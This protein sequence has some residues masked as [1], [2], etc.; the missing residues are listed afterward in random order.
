MNFRKILPRSEIDIPKS[1]EE[2]TELI[3]KI[4]H[5]EIKRKFASVDSTPPAASKKKSLVIPKSQKLFLPLASRNTGQN[6]LGVLNLTAYPSS[7]AT[8]SP[9]KSPRSIL[10]EPNSPR[11]KA[12]PSPKLSVLK[13]RRNFQESLSK[14]EGK[15]EEPKKE[16]TR[17]K[18]AKEEAESKKQ[19]HREMVRGLFGK[20]DFLVCGGL[21]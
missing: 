12:S 6:D 19:E 5:R 20:L 14:F 2:Q 10:I 21:G 15:T 9:R 4:V 18:M 11:T 13:A 7:V 8:V 3:Q 1:K 17:K 16:T